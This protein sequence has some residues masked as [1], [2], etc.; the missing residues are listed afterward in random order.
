MRHGSHTGSYSEGGSPYGPINANPPRAIHSYANN[1]VNI[2]GGEWDSLLTADGPGNRVTFM[3][4]RGRHAFPICVLQGV[5]LA[6]T[7]GGLWVIPP[8]PFEILPYAG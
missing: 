6:V 4:L 3:H 1:L 5:F 7:L 8:S 2:I